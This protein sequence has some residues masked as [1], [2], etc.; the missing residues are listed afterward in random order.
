MSERFWKILWN[1][2]RIAILKQFQKIFWPNVCSKR[3]VGICILA[4]TFKNL[5]FIH[6]KWQLRIDTDNFFNIKVFNIIREITH[7]RIDI[8]VVGIY[9]FH[10][11]YFSCQ[12][13]FKSRVR[14]FLFKCTPTSIAL[15]IL[16][17]FKIAPLPCYPLHE[18]NHDDLQEIK[19]AS[20]IIQGKAKFQR[21][22]KSEMD[23]VIY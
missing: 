8:E 13:N 6:S 10:F 21:R 17:V 4:P 1:L 11:T 19:M 3:L 2:S 9:F 14:T 15:T 18:N 20:R 12:T 7:G 22:R 23:L 16:W 5:D